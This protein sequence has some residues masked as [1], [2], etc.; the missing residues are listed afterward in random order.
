M[1]IMFNRPIGAGNI[2]NAQDSKQAYCYSI[3]K[4]VNWSSPKVIN[5]D[6]TGGAVIRIVALLMIQ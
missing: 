3:D 5:P 4:E 6:E 1:F 2:R